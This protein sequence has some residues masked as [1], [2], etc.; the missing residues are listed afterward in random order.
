M[1]SKLKS[2]NLEAWAKI[3][4]QMH[5]TYITPNNLEKEQSGKTEIS[6]DFKR[7]IIYSDKDRVVWCKYTHK[8]NEI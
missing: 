4:M 8:I 7:V 1:K 5:R 6:C 3:H 2:R